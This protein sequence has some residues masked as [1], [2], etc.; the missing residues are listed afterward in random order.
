MTGRRGDSFAPFVGGWLACLALAGCADL[1]FGLGLPAERGV[2]GR[3]ILAARDFERIGFRVEGGGLYVTY[4]VRLPQPDA[5][6]KPAFDLM[7]VPWNGGP[8]G[9]GAR[10]VLA[11][12]S[13]RWSEAAPPA[14]ARGVHY[15]MVDER[16]IA[17]GTGAATTVGTLVRFDY[18][19]GEIERIEGVVS[20]SVSGRH[21]YYRS[22]TPGESDPGLHL[23]DLD[24]NERAIGATTGAVQWGPGGEL[25]F[26]AGKDRVLSRL[27][28]IDGAIEPL[29][30][31]VSRYQLRDAR[32][33]AVSRTVDR[34]SVAAILSLTDGVETPLA[35]GDP[36][37]WIG[38]YGDE[39]VYAEAATDAGPARL[40]FL[41]VGAGVDRF[42]EVPAPLVDV[43]G[44]MPRPESQQWLLFDRQ[45][46]TAVYDPTADPPVRSLD[47]RPASPRFTD[48]GRHIL[49]IE[50]R[51]LAANKLE[52]DLM[53]RDAAF[54]APP[55]Q[56][57]PR[58]LYVERGSFFFVGGDEPLVFW[59]HYG[60][61]GAGHASDL[62]Q[63]NHELGTARVIAEGITE[64][65]V[66]PV[67]LSGVVRVSQQD[68][69]GDLVRKNTVT[70]EE[71]I[72]AH[73]VA[74]FASFGRA[75]GRAP[76][77]CLEKVCVAFQI[78]ERVPSSR[79]GLWATFFP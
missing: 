4:E 42:V 52:G 79:E 35:G 12:K 36:C 25:Y 2:R 45:G 27:A 60:Q 56:I 19:A 47:F 58:G 22:V 73:S 23:R 32:F 78:R 34:K 50:P 24:G 77:P 44:W 66:G 57:S 68:L 46:H 61:E 54:L 62:Y 40:H 33:A 37:C 64:V 75:L 48:D 53:I 20:F 69:V 1:P 67:S 71:T 5:R 16:V 9:E 26:V 10:R 70:G 3:Q 17:T 55:R 74:D 41:E 14:D 51:I 65:T 30:S 76:E 6:L 8:T 38:F 28:T 49:Y 59:G 72:Y 39:F 29:A 31:G 18:L 7:M 11:N 21:L 13:D 43:A 15:A 63:A